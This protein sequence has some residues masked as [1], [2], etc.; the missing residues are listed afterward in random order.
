M[1]KLLMVAV[2]ATLAFTAIACGPPATTKA[3]DKKPEST[4]KKEEKKEEKK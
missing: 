3:T 2:L 4:E 1:K